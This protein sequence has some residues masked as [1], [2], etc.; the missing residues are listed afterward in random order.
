[1][2]KAVFSASLLHSSCHMIFRNHNNMLIYYQCWNCCAAS[3][4]LGHVIIFQDTLINK[5]LKR[6]MFI[7]NINFVFQYALLFKSLGSVINFFKESNT[8]I[9]DECVKWIKGDSKDLY[10]VKSI[11]FLINAVLKTLLI[12]E[13]SITLQKQQAAQQFQH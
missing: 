3:Y 6:T 9:H 1:M 10:S 5:K 8:F 11:L 13:K 7:K 12:K 2:I 4:C